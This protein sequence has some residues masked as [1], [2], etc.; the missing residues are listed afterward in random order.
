MKKISAVLAALVILAFAGCASS[1]GGASSSS[2]GS[3]NPPY[4]VDLS[5][6]QICPV[7]GGGVVGSPIGTGPRNLTPLTKAW[8]D[9]FLLF[10]E[11]PAN[12]TS[13]T[14]LT[15]NAKYYDVAAD[16]KSVGEEITQGDSNVIVSLIYDFNPGDIRGPAQGP[17]ANTPVKE[18]N[19]GGFSGLISTEKG[20]RVRFS[21]PPKAILFQNNHVGV[22]FI[23][24]TEITFHD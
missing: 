24:V 12:I 13:Y 15:V 9:V 22:K 5:K 4:S 21:K 16:G 14:R 23:E 18:F 7:G 6:L 20:I 11:L 17:G 2:S 3:G 1:G 10:P 19:V 8:D